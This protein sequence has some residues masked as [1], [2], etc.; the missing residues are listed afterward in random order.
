MKYFI[1]S[2]IHGS[3]TALTNI[4]KI[5]ETEKADILVICGDFLNHGP[6]NKI[7]EGYNPQEVAQMLN[8]I[9]NKIICVRGNCD[10]EVDQMLLD[11][12]CLDS[13]TTIFTNFSNNKYIRFFIHH[14]HL[15]TENQLK[16]KLEKKTIIISG[17]THIPLIKEED[18]YYFLNPGSISIPKAN[19]QQCYAIIEDNLSC[20]S[21]NIYIKNL[22]DKIIAQKNIEC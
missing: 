18:N 9:K 5:F 13:S 19:S 15:Y 11:F 20:N 6:R 3:S 12:P 14:G 16:E 7:P 1:I 21:I 10:S 8:K 2:D 17:H 4:L 22:N